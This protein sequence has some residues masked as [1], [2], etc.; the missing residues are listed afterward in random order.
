[1]VELKADMAA[2]MD[3]VVVVTCSAGQP[4][5]E[6]PSQDCMHGQEEADINA[7]SW[8]IT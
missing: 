2:G 6:I 7:Q 8:S 1:M 5:S 3:P 4:A